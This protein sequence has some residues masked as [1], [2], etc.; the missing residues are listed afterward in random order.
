MTSLARLAASSVQA[1][2]DVRT[3]EAAIQAEATS[4]FGQQARRVAHEAGNPL[5]IITNYL[6][7]VS[8][9]I[10]PATGVRMELDIL[11]EEIDRVAQI[12]RQLGDVPS[13]VSASARVDVNAVI[14]G[15]AALYRE[16]IFSSCGVT[17]DLELDRSLPT[18][19]G[20]R[21]QIKQIV[22]NLWRNAADAMGNG[23]RMTVSTADRAAPDGQGYL[24]MRF[25]DTGPGL[26]P[27]VA[28]NDFR[29]LDA[30]RRPGHAGVG[31]SIVAALVKELDGKISF[32]SRPGQGTTFVIQLPKFER[33]PK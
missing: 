2:R 32:E 30:N 27:D 15:M 33:N 1:R 13:L 24:E 29:P 5:A 3:R 17:L 9:R 18:I 16:S 19:P 7:I 8:E 4:R 11:K 6:K 14:A 22:I 28:G 21:D 31:L 23:G 10:P 25:A 26:P 20:S 12:I